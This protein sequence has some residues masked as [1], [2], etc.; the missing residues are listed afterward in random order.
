M[1][2][3]PTHPEW[4]TVGAEAVIYAGG[5]MHRTV[6]TKL[7]PQSIVTKCGTRFTLGRFGWTAKSARS[8]GPRTLLAGDHPKAVAYFREEDRRASAHDAEAALIAWRRDGATPET[9]AA[10]RAALDALAPHLAETED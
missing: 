2:T 5:S 1:T 6:I 4:A 3:A 9:I 8:W 7:T 10:L